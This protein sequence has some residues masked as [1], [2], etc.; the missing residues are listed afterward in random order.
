[1][2]PT[3]TRPGCQCLAIALLLCQPLANMA[4]TTYSAAMA[5]IGAMSR[6][7][8]AADAGTDLLPAEAP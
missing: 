4:C 8:I 5:D 3:A 1:M 6:A 2:M 7:A